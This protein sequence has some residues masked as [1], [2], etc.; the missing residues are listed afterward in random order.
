[1]YSEFYHPKHSEELAAIFRDF[2][3]DE[4]LLNYISIH[5]YK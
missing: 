3:T 4:T 5:L 2:W 1:M